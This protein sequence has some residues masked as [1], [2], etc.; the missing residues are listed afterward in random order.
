MAD[1]APFRFHHCCHPDLSWSPQPL[2]PPLAACHAAARDA[3]SYS[4]E[5]NR[6]LVTETC[7]VGH[8]SCESKTDKL[9]SFKAKVSLRLGDNSLNMVQVFG[10]CTVSGISVAFG[11]LAD[12][13]AVDGVSTVFLIPAVWGLPSA[14]YIC[15]VP[16]VS[17]F[18]HLIVA[19]VLVELCCCC[20]CPCFCWRSYFVGGPVVAFIPVVACV[21]AIAVILEVACCWHHCCF[22]HSC[23]CLCHCTENC[24]EI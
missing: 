14:G 10:I 2:F 6:L 11:V 18:F 21:H 24:D 15:G 17:A 20:R 19:N 8:L 3:F 1:S 23:C 13:N 9:A 12:A 4:R 22:W 5:W 16:I 7:R